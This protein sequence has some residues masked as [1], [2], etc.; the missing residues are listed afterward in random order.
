MTALVAKGLAPG[1]ASKRSHRRRD[2]AVEMED[3]DEA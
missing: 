3:K 1:I 2:L